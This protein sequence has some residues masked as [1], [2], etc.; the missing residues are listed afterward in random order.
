M[1]SLTEPNSDQIQK[2]DIFVQIPRDAMLWMLRIKPIND[3]A[4]I[5]KAKDDDQ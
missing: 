3:T 5:S 2:L 1:T 4:R